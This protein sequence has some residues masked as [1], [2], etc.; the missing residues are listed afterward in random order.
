MWES[1]LVWKNRWK[2]KLQP[3]RKRLDKWLTPTMKVGFA[4]IPTVVCPGYDVETVIY[5]DNATWDQS[6]ILFENWVLAR[7]A[8]Q[9]LNKKMRQPQ[10][11]PGTVKYSWIKAMIMKQNRSLTWVNPEWR[12]NACMAPNIRIAGFWRLLPDFLE[13]RGW[14]TSPK[15][16]YSQSGMPFGCT[17]QTIWNQPKKH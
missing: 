10:E 16:L 7:W 15:Y 3:S 17:N 9:F 8:V 5:I 2:S 13:I 12:R 11:D 6:T 4:P 14:I 1:T